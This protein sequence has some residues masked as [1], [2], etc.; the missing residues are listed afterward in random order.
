MQQLHGNEASAFSLPFPFRVKVWTRPALE[1]ALLVHCKRFVEIILGYRAV[2][3]RR[4]EMGEEIKMEKHSSRLWKIF[5]SVV[6]T[7]HKTPVEIKNGKLPVFCLNIFYIAIPYVYVLL[8]LSNITFKENVPTVYRPAF[9]R[10]LSLVTVR[11]K[12][13]TN[14]FYCNHKS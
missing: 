11:A 6:F 5:I 8:A 3:E 9:K 7:F 12:K 14:Y 13:E 1:M 2:E 4:S 10:E